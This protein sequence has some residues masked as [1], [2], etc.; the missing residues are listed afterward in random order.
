[1]TICETAMAL[2]TL[3][4]R[5]ILKMTHL[6]QTWPFR[7][8]AMKA[9]IFAFVFLGLSIVTRA[10]DAKTVTKTSNHLF[11]IPKEVVVFVEYLIESDAAIRTKYARLIAPTQKAAGGRFSVGPFTAIEWLVP[12]ANVEFQATGGTR[13]YEGVYLVRR[14]LRIGFH[15]GYSVS[16]N[17]VV[18]V[19]VKE[20][21]DLKRD[22][23]KE[24]DFIL[25]RTEL[26]LHFDGFVSVQ[27]NPQ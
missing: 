24:D 14:Q 4:C 27:L 9:T 15:R 16:D 12:E 19:T 6:L 20:H 13:D 22:P 10:D 1:M 3:Q 11:D 18:R 23:Q 2:G 26:T 7:R 25:T 17:V 8:K 5:Q 21:Q